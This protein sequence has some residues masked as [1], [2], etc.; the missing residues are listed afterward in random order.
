MI[1][2]TKETVAKSGY[3]G[4]YVQYFAR[5]EKTFGAQPAIC[6]RNATY[7]TRDM[8][9]G[10]DVTDNLTW[11]TPANLR[12]QGWVRTTVMCYILTDLGAFCF[13][14]MP[15]AYSR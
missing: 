1:L 2:F 8:Y 5:H 14:S 4:G 12:Y 3:N 11:R 15:P 6:K 13:G 7:E 10:R 9:M